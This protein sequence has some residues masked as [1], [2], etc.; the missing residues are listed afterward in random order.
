VTITVILVVCAVFLGY[1]RVFASRP[2]KSACCVKCQ[3]LNGRWC[4][5]PIQ[6]SRAVAEKNAWCRCRFQYAL[7]KFTAASRGSPCDSTAFQRRLRFEYAY[8]TVLY[9][10]RPISL[11][12]KKPSKNL[13]CMVN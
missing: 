5:R 12:T 6:E 4:T 8:R 7:S 1:R 3:H 13:L 10:Y 9:S 2:W 11:G